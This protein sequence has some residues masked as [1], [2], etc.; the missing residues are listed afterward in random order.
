MKQH[1]IEEIEAAF[2][3]ILDEDAKVSYHYYSHLEITVEEKTK[4]KVVIK[5]H[6]QYEHPAMN[7]S[8]MKALADFFGTDD[9]NDDDKYSYG[10]CETCDYGSK[11]GYTLT[12]RA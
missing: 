2:R 8:I 3:R 7:L 11:Y 4:K 10:G 12:V 5:V 6:A 1:S 9:I